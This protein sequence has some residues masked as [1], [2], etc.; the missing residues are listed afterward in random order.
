MKPF[1]LLLIASLFL[2]SCNSPMY[3]Q[4][5]WII[6]WITGIGAI[7]C[8]A[9]A[10]LASRSNSTTEIDGRVYD[11]TGNVPIYK[12]PFFWFGV[13]LTIATILINISYAADK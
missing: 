10:F 2:V 4:G 5:G 7:I 6:P 11:N 13:V 12:I 8:F 9:I 3:H 1:I